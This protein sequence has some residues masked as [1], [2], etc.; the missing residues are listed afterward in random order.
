[1]TRVLEDE[2]DSMRP[3]PSLLSHNPPWLN[4]DTPASCL[5]NALLHQ[6]FSH[7]GSYGQTPWTINSPFGPLCFE[8][9]YI[10]FLF[11]Y[12]NT[13][14]TNMCKLYIPMD[15]D[16]KKT[17]MKNMWFIRLAGT[18][19][20]LLWFCFQSYSKKH[21]RWLIRIHTIRFFKIINFKGQHK[22]K[23]VME[24]NKKMCVWE[25]EREK[26]RKKKKDRRAGLQ[27]LATVAAPSIL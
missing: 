23:V 3:G 22:G 24:S 2:S 13:L 6:Q 17:Q 8:R 18:E 26:E 4:I 20:S 19:V 7:Q 27:N 15:K 25:R 21:M 10:I 12:S 16:W 1:M 5:P 14:T 11:F 9:G